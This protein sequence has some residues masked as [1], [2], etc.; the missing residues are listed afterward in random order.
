MNITPRALT[1]SADDW[2]HASTRWAEVTNRVAERGHERAEEAAQI[3]IGLRL[4]AWL[5]RQGH[6]L[7][8][9][10]RALNAIGLRSEANRRWTIARLRRAVG[11]SPEIVE[12]ANRD[13]NDGAGEQ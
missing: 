7:P 1:S 4:V 13:H 9:A 6:E 5:L 12:Q 10:V 2:S 11:S 3:G 8:D